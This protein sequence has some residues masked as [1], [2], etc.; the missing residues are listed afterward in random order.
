MCAAV[1]LIL[2]IIPQTPV[3]ICLLCAELHKVRG[4]VYSLTALS[5]PYNRTTI[6]FSAYLTSYRGWCFEAEQ[7]IHGGQK[8]AAADLPSLCLARRNMALIHPTVVPFLCSPVGW[9]GFTGGGPG[10][11][12]GLWRASD[13]RSFRG[14]V[15]KVYSLAPTDVDRGEIADMFI[16]NYVNWLIVGMETKNLISIHQ[17]MFSDSH[18]YEDKCEPWLMLKV[19]V[20]CC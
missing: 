20:S 10:A 1:S 5:L 11:S 16:E 15:W 3:E 18:S 17:W 8:L 13:T 7:V 14:H 6:S 4:K 9:G 19:A 12:R 2:T